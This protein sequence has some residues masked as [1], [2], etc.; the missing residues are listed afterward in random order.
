MVDL[1]KL[2][3]YA[4]SI[5]S[6]NN[7]DFVGRRISAKV[8]GVTFE[9]RQKVLAQ[10]TTKTLVKLERERRNKFDFN[11]V[12]VLVQVN[13]G[14][15]QAGYLPM[16]MSGSIAK[17][18]DKGIAFKA[19]VSRVVGGGTHMESKTKLNYGLNIVIESE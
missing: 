18:M 9:G 6:N 10:I 17:N 13:G 7:N 16:S 3:H 4:D 12:K 1:N 8:S 2:R 11:A 5:R 19:E 14:W 15:L